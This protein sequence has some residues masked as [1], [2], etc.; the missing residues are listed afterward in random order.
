MHVPPPKGFLEPHEVLRVAFAHLILGIDQNHLATLFNVNSGR[1][2][3]A[4]MAVRWAVTNHKSVYADVAEAKKAFK[5]K[6]VTDANGVSENIQE[7][8]TF[9]VDKM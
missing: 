4:V 7:L 5:N 1:I 3:E 2:A 9:R 6:G 8:L